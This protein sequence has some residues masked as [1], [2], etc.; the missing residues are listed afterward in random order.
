[1]KV[2]VTGPNLAHP[3]DLTYGGGAELAH[4]LTLDPGATP[5]SGDVYTAQVVY[6]DETTATLN[7]TLAG[8][9]QGAPVLLTPAWSESNVSHTPTL[10]WSA[11]TGAQPAAWNYIAYVQDLATGDFV[12]TSQVPSTDTSV[13]VGPVGTFTQLNPSTTYVWGVL[14][15]DSAGNTTSGGYVGFVTAP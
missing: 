7:L 11:P 8:A 14:A 12:W 6:S 5:A 10:S 13:T 4:V 1:V 3:T 15:S 2:T 9:F